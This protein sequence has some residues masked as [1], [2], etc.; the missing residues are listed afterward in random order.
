MPSS[1]SSFLTATDS[2]GWLTK[3]ASAAWPKWRSRATATM[4]RNS[5][6]VM[7]ALKWNGVNLTIANSYQQ[8]KGLRKLKVRLSGFCLP[9]SYVDP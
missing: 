9:F 5:V 8:D 3:Q 2:V 1:S 4:Y 7:K 6:S